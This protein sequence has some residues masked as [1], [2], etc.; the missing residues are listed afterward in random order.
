MSFPVPT[1]VA[2]NVRSPNHPAAVTRRAS[3]LSGRVLQ[4]LIRSRGSARAS[5]GPW[6]RDERRQRFLDNPFDFRQD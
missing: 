3:R 2:M 1:V 5:A 6:P 4:A